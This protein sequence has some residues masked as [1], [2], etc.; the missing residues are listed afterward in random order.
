MDWNDF[1][2]AFIA[3]FEPVTETE[4]ARKQLRNLRQTG[5]VSAYIAKFNELQCRLPGMN[6]EEAFSTF[7]SRLTPHLLEHIGAHV[8]GDLERA[9]Q[10]ALRMDM[11]KGGIDAGKGQQGQQQQQR[12]KG[13]QKKG[14]VHMVEAQGQDGG[15]QVNAVKGKQQKRGGGQ[16]QNQGQGKKGQ[17]KGQG[18]RQ[19]QGDRGPLKCF[20]CGGS[21]PLRKCNVFNTMRQ[22]CGMGQSENS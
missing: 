13:G 2:A 1:Q 10:M 7:L 14:S 8:Q 20:A 21:H 15:D 16:G 17:K 18:N 6:V 5:R 22:K 3:A 11:F 19:G 4:E 12:G 9:K